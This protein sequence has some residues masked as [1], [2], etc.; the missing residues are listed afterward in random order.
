MVGLMTGADDYGTRAN[1]SMICLGTTPPPPPAITAGCTVTKLLFP[2][3]Y[4]GVVTKQQG[5]KCFIM[6]TAFT[7][8]G[9]NSVV[10][11]GQTVNSKQKVERSSK[12]REEQSQGWGWPGINP[13]GQTSLKT[14]YMKGQLV[15]KEAC[16]DLKS[17]CKRTCKEAVAD[18]L[19]RFPPPRDC[20]VGEWTSYS[21]CSKSCGGGNQYATR[22]ILYP[23]KFGGKACPSTTKYRVCAQVPCLNPN[24]IE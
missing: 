7:N 10:Q 21:S 1:A 12:S 13:T 4:E 3:R 18:A 19:Y 5:E 17:G 2:L 22:P 8:I 6:W 23:A 16:G 20:I 15:M 11:W 14:T 24:F 9:N